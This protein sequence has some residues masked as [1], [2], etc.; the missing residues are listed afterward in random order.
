MYFVIDFGWEY[1]LLIAAGFAA[2]FINTLAGGGSL[3]TLPMLIFLGLPPAV[4]NGTNRIAI[5]IQ[6]FFATAGFKSKGVSTFP[7]N[8]YLG[9]SA[10][11]GA[12]L[13]AK[14]A[15]DISGDLFNKILAII[16]IVVVALLVFKPK[17]E[18]SLQKERL[19]G[20]H[21]WVAIIAFFFIGIYGGFINA[22]IG[23]IIMLFL[24]YFN[25]MSLTR[26]NATKVSLVFVY[27]IGAVIMFAL[28]DKIEWVVGFILAI[29]NASGAWF[30]SR[31]SVKKGDS[32]IKAVMVIMVAIMAVKLW[33]F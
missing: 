21:L 15:I 13:G 10:M 22:G 33:F 19:T 29:G 7:F 26:V 32:V 2:G 3:L 11:L 25:K 28:N 5:L 23:F 17:M 16:M 18:V 24:H 8:I 30:G 4:A 31:W 6:T 1:L 9:I 27:T 20:F 12:F 14:I